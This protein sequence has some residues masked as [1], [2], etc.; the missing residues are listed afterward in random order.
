MSNAAFVICS[1]LTSS[2]VPSKPL[3][4][5]NGIT[6]IEHLINRLLET[7]YNVIVAVPENESVNY[8]FLLDRFPK[9][10]S[11]FMG[12][13]DDPMAR[14]HAAAHA[15]KLDYVIR[16]TH[17]K[18]FIDTEKVKPMLSEAITNNVDYV[19]SSDFIPGTGFEIL[20]YACLSKC[21]EKYKRVEHVSYAAKATTK[22][23]LNYRF[24]K[25]VYD[26]RLLIDYI[27]DV[28]LMR[29]IF[30]TIGSDCTL[31]QVLR[32]LEVNRSL[33]G[34]NKLPLITV[35][36]CAYNAAK[37]IQQAIGSVA[38]QSNFKDCEYI[39]IDDHSTDKTM[40]PVA[41]FCQ[42]YKNSKFIR[43]DKNL[44]LASSSNLAL[45]NA[46]GQFI[47]R[48]DADDF[49][50][51]KNIIQNMVTEIEAQNLDALY[52]N[53]YAGLSC[54]RI[55]K[56]EQNH[57]SGGTLFRTSAINHIKFTDNLRNYDSLDLFLRAKDQIK[58]G[59]W[60][61]VAFCYRQHNESMSKRN[62]EDREKT[63]KLIEEKYGE[64][65]SNA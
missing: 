28:N 15:H 32:F 3:I 18:I 8:A 24:Q 17:D 51:N 1:R 43:N 56:G 55:Q 26:V 14:M 7:E 39:I 2:R 58:I 37:W 21:A 33:K 44:G 42:N 34:L 64:K 46:R 63:K 62:F 35:Y 25:R 12:F 31:Q 11:L 36:T 65:A 54:K 61:R 41:K 52:P 50:I 40:L 19:Y 27:E 47:I 53:C 16:I 20:S 38:M 60:N 29:V 13:E 59:Y 9:K 57:H 48:L 23:T 6:Q 5:Y 45:K 30:A 22:N 49:F 4:L 10:V